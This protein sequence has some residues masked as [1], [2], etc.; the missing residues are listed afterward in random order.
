[1][2]KLLVTGCNGLVGSEMCRY[3][4]NK[5]WFVVGVDND[6]RKRFF[7]EEG[8]THNVASDVDEFVYADIVGGIHDV[9]LEY[10]FDMII[11]TDS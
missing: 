1:M 3:F 4:K 2:K 11:V 7:G 9:F 10:D 6:S 5:G 8:S